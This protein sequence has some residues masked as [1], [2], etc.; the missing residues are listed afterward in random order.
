M[1]GE[2]DIVLSF[3]R[4]AYWV[5]SVEADVC[6]YCKFVF[7]MARFTYTSINYTRGTSL[8]SE[9]PLVFVCS[10]SSTRVDGYKAALKDRAFK[11]FSWH[12]SP[13][14]V[15]DV[16]E[17]FSALNGLMTDAIEALVGGAL[18]Q[19]AAVGAIGAQFDV[20]ERFGLESLR[21]FATAAVPACMKPSSVCF[22]NHTGE[23]HDPRG[24]VVATHKADT[25]DFAD[26]IVKDGP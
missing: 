12:L 16:F 14:A 6:N 21:K 22:L 11:F 2:P 1:Y 18:L 17:V 15:R 5:M 9:V 25:G 24:V 7:D 26:V 13:E 3:I 10:K 23:L 8:R 20:V 19:R 4:Y